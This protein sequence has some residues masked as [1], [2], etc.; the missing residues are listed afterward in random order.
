MFKFIDTQYGPRVNVVLT[1][2]ETTEAVYWSPR[3]WRLEGTGDNEV[4]VPAGGFNS[5]VLV[6][7]ANGGWVARDGKRC[8]LVCVNGAGEVRWEVLPSLL[9][10]RG[11]EEP[12]HLA[13]ATGAVRHFRLRSALD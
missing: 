2:H 9:L 7:D 5:H 13:E 8:R 1:H 10:V 11:F 12:H 4:K 3:R 6:E